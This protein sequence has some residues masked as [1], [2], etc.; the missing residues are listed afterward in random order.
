MTL[1]T[2]LKPGW[3]DQGSTGLESQTLVVFT[4]QWGKASS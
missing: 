3:A 1:E 4:F 2:Y